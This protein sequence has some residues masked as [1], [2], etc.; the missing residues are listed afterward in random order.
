MIIKKGTHAP[1][2]L[3][4]LLINPKLIS[5]R[6]V[7]TE[8]CAY[9]IGNDQGDINKLFGIG[10]L[11]HHHHNSV[12]IGWNYENN[13]I[14]IFAYWYEKKVR[15]WKLLE[16]IDTNTS[17]TFSIFMQ[18]NAHI[19]YYGKKSYAINV[20]SNCVGYLLGPYFGG[21]RTAPHDIE[22]DIIQL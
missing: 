18:K 3:P 5:Y 15:W 10:Y 7:F 6:V 22:I 12:R 2:T 14:N 21:N 8:S 19:I 9:N 16:K 1:L 20:K 13:K 17:H 11:P 4:K